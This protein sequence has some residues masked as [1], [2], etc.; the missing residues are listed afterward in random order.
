MRHDIHDILKG[1]RPNFDLL[2]DTYSKYYALSERLSAGKV[3]F[4]WRKNFK[5]K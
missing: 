4:K 5:F 2:T 3:L 1:V